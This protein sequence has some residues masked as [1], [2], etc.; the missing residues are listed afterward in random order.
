MELTP[1]GIEGAWL[2]ESPIFFDER[3]SFRE[4]FKYQG[5]IKHIIP[6]FQV[7]QSNV[8]ISSKG[9]IRGIHF[10]QGS[11]GQ[12]KWVTCLKGEILDVIVDLREHS[13]TFGNWIGISL[14]ASTGKSVFI[15][16][17]LG[18]A[19]IALEEETIVSYSLSRVYDPKLEKGISPLDPELKIEWPLSNW[20]ISE[21]DKRAPTLREFF[22]K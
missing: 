5:A 7:V 18:H 6:E 11:S 13:P 12:S 14:A 9:V 2:A 1:L 21:K 16:S 22:Q 8:S 20:V 3:G 19:F 17:G 15:P 10:T 4:W